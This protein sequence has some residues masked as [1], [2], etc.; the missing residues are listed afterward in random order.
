[1]FS[2]VTDGELSHGHFLHVNQNGL[3]HRSQERSHALER[4]PL[5]TARSSLVLLIYVT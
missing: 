5:Q 4:S 2:P 1:M 3:L